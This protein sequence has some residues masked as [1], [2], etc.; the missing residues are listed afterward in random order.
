MQNT[1]D[2]LKA[3]ISKDLLQSDATLAD[4]SLLIE[5]GILTSLQTIE[6]VGFIDAE[7]GIEVEPEEIN[8]EEFRS[9]RTIAALI[10]RKRVG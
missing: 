3:Y 8:E 5:S 2:T 9:L 7:F 1:I 4:D 6:L 10:E